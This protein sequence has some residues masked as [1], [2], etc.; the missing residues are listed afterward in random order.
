MDNGLND[1]LGGRCRKEG[2]EN[3]LSLQWVIR[4]GKGVIEGIKVVIRG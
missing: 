4:G 3:V 1:Y 2:F